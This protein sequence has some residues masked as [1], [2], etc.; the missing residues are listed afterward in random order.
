MQR[1]LDR[2]RDDTEEICFRPRGMSMALQRRCPLFIFTIH[3][4]PILFALLVVSTVNWL[5]F[6]LTWPHP[7]LPYFKPLQ[8]HRL[9]A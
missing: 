7:L 6:A 2:F 3:S 8:S 1:K 9:D 5:H 4:V